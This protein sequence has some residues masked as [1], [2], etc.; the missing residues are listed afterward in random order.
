VPKDDIRAFLGTFAE[1]FGFRDRDELK[2]APDDE[3]L[4]VYRAQYPVKDKC[5]R[6]REAMT[7]NNAFES[8][9]GPTSLARP[10]HRML[11]ADPLPRLAGIAVLRRL[12]VSDLAVFQEYRHDPL[13]ARYQ[14]WY[15][16]KTDAEA[17]AFLAKMNALELLQPGICS[18]IGI[19]EPDQLALVGDIG[20]TLAIDGKSAEIGYALRPEAQGRG[21]GAAAVREVINLVFERTDAERVLGIVDPLN[22]RSIRLLERVG[23]RMIESR[24]G[25]F[26]DAPCIDHVYAILRRA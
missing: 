12:E 8:D 10:S 3:L 23:M 18:Q 21:M 5:S 7:P 11:P 13:I 19:A 24:S 15:G 25:I 16:T 6:Y 17:S 14:D 9:R 20:L 4:Q 26:R 2:F 22:V 1:G